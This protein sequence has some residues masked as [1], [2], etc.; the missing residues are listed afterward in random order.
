METTE[1]LHRHYL[2]GWRFKTVL[3]TLLLTILGYFLF[4]LWAGWDNVVLAFSKVGLVGIIIALALSFCNLTLRF[5]RWQYFLHTLV[6]EV[7]N[8]RVSFRIY[9]SGFSLT[10]TP[11]K[12]GEAIRCLFL[13]DYN[14]PFRKSFG[15]FFAE[16]FCDLISVSILATGALFVYPSA[17]VV[18][19]FILSFFLLIFLVIKKEQRI[20]RL[21]TW[22]KKILP[23]RFHS[24]IEFVRETILSFRSCFSTT[25]LCVAI[26]IGVFAWFMEALALYIL[27]YLVGYPLDLLSATFTYAFSLVVGGISMLPGGLGGAEVTMFKLLSLNGTPAGI[28]VA[29]TLVIRIT[30]LWFSVICGFFMLPKNTLFRLTIDQ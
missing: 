14:I 12:T 2:S 17:R 29:I 13:K 1:H 10:T 5:L 22:F 21:E 15:A 28:A 3:I 9:L 24:A 23:V 18:L 30:S 20:Y 11:G 16:R 8:W 19:F 7:P 26:V 25:T 6:Q 27:L 4:T